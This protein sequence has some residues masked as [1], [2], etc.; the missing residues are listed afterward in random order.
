[1]DIRFLIV[2]LCFIFCS[3]NTAL[4]RPYHANLYEQ[5]L[6]QL[7][8]EQVVSNQEMFLINHVILR[9]RTYL[10][11]TVKGKS[12]ADILALGKDMAANGMKVKS[13]FP[14]AEAPEDLDVTI[15]NEGSSYNENK[16][17]LKFTAVFKN[18]STQPIALLD[19]S[20]LVYGP[21]KEHIT[22]AA[23]EINTRID[24]GKSEKLFFL[25][26][27]KNMREN[28]LFG[29][30][31][32]M[33]RLFMDDIIIQADIQLGGASVTSKNVNSFNTFNSKEEYILAD[34]EFSYPRELKGTDWY[35]KD[36]N[37]KATVFKPGLKHYPQ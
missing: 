5:D 27:A 6:K 30:D 29:R 23:Y 12:Y 15:S 20:F 18:T 25:V 10:D 28:L 22:T 14:Y 13:I 36:A 1:M 32:S 8:I 9:E 33:A 2:G 34:K 31:F 3:C 19:A 11:Y 17:V 4:D 21:F 35:E 24:A 16:K 26:D 7:G 37:G